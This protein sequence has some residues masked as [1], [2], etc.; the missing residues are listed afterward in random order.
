MVSNEEVNLK[1]PNKATKHQQS[2]KV[3][4]LVEVFCKEKTTLIEFLFLPYKNLG[5]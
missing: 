5:N 2:S 1:H 3:F 4:V